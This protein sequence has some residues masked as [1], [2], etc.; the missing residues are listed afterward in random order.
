MEVEA[1]RFAER[2]RLSK[3][4]RR[5]AITS[6]HHRA[7]NNLPKDL[8]ERAQA[9]FTASRWSFDSPPVSVDTPARP[10]VYGDSTQSRY[11]NTF[12]G[13]PRD[14]PLT[15]A[16][17][18]HVHLPRV[19]PI[20]GITVTPDGE[21]VYCDAYGRIN[22]QLQGLDPQDHEHA[23]GM[24]TNGTQGDSAWVR[25]MTGLAGDRKGRRGPW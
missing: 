6:L 2:E 15:P 5:I 14:L 8:H 17:D 21:E 24:G 18:P 19:H 3:S 9:L 11:E 12:S 25:V 13:V 1:G 20:V 16:Y 23:N 7:E 4:E 10:S 22:V